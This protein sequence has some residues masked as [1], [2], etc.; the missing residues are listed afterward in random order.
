MGKGHIKRLAAPKSWPIKRKVN[1]WITRPNAG[2]HNFNSSIAIGTVIKDLLDYVKNRKET[3]YVLSADKVAVNGK[4]RKDLKFPIG[5][6]DVLTVGEDNFRLIINKKG[7]LTPVAI[8]KIESKLVLKKVLNKT[9]LKNKKVQ[10]NFEDGSNLLSNEKYQTGDTVVF[11][12]DKVKDHLKFEKGAMIYITAGKQVGQV[13]V[14]K[15]VKEKKGLQ[16]TTIIFTQG[17][18]NHETPKKYVFIVGKTKP[19]V[20]LSE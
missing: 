11:S 7:K 3:K 4:I 17:K 9:Y 13:G 10:V 12:D 18:E 15:E 6:M 14:I 20:S 8:T 5:I 19:L 1:T 2:P 16:P